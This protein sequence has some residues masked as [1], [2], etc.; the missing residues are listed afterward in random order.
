MSALTY[1]SQNKTLDALFRGQALS[2]PAT[3]YFALIKATRGKSNSIRSTVVTSGDTVIPATPNGHMYRCTTGGTTGS[4]EPTWSTTSGA[5]VSDGGTVVWTEMTP[6]FLANTNL[7]EVS[8]SSTGYSRVGVASSLANF[9]GTQG[10]G[11]TTASSGTSGTTSNNGTIT[12]GA[13]IADWGVIAFLMTFDA[14]T[15]GDAWTFEP[16]TN[17]KTVNNGDSAPTIAAAAFTE[18][19]T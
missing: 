3:Q 8:T 12:F 4:G 15:A 19:L 11:T 18:Q 16:L 10:A 1:F 14:S 6:D 9:A 13:P 2:A 17:P 5:T 7:T